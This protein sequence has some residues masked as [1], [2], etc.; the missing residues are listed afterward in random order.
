MRVIKENNVERQVK[1]GN[2]KSIIAYK[3]KDVVNGMLL[4]M[5]CCPVCSQLIEVSKFDK[6][7][8]NYEKR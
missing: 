7:V 3:A 1:C 8:R 5:I 2:C 6:K 4:H